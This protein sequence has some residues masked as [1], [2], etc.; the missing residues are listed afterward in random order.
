MELVP[1]SL[2]VARVLR[3]LH[4][5]TRELFVLVMREGVRDTT[6]Q[7]EREKE[8][9]GRGR[10]RKRVEEEEERKREHEISHIPHWQMR[11]ARV[12]DG[13]PGQPRGRRFRDRGGRVKPAA[14]DRASDLLL[15][16]DDGKCRH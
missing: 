12:V 9:E 10:E 3:R 1:C 14:L 11:T 4:D 13:F 5:T 16:T 6:G 7:R 8:G 2:M 15:T